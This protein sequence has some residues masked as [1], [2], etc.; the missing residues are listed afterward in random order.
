MVG[1]KIL[2]ININE[3]GMKKTSST[4]VP[5]AILYSRSIITAH[6]NKNNAPSIIHRL[7]LHLN[8]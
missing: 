7:M 6:T 8:H 1:S 3:L 5:L 4:S 2:S